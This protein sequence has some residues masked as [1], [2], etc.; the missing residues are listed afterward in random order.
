MSKISQ[1]LG[2]P[3]VFNIGGVDLTIKPLTIDDLELFSIDQNAPMEEQVKQ[4]KKLIQ[5][6]IKDAVP[7]ATEE[8]IKSISVEHL[9]ELMDAIM[10]VN[11]LS[12]DRIKPIQ[13]A[14]QAGTAQTKG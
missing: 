3:Q 11:K 5:K 1:L 8:E 2:K 14:L 12:K 7:D 13:N 9:E 6:V 10:K 4:T